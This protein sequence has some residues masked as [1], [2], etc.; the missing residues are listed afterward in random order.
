MNTAHVLAVPPP[1]GHFVISSDDEID[2]QTVQAVSVSEEVE[3]SAG[4][5]SDSSDAGVNAAWPQKSLYSGQLGTKMHALPTRSS[6]SIVRRFG[7]GQ[8][9]P[10]LAAAALFAA[11]LLTTMRVNPFAMVETGKDWHN[12][13]EVAVA[14]LQVQAAAMREQLAE[15]EQRE[16]HEFEAERGLRELAERRI[17]QCRIYGPSFC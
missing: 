9:F 7:F 16:H 3:T 14:E 8:T 1:Q 11:L 13:T 17:E 15:R 5:D 4:P 6:A 2:S 10:G 12:Q